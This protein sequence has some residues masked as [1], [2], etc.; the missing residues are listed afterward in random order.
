MSA[1]VFVPS[2]WICGT[3]S[4]SMMDVRKRG[5]P[6][7]GFNANGG[8]KKSKHGQFFSFLY[9]LKL[10]SFDLHRLWFICNKI[11]PITMGLMC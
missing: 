5:R 3:N 2:F 8:L 4:K 7:A 6:E 11:E 1:L 9:L 10:F